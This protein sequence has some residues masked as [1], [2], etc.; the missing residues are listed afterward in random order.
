M[1]LSNLLHGCTDNDFRMVTGKFAPPP[2]RGD[3]PGVTK[4]RG[5]RL[6]L[7]TKFVAKSSLG[8]GRD[9]AEY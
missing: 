2:F 6:F 1:K 9:L 8:D 4:Q 7:E 3:K 5:R